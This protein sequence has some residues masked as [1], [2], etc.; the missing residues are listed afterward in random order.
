MVSPL[1]KTNVA[2]SCWM[3]ANEG[4]C[5][6]SAGR[7]DEFGTEDEL[8]MSGWSWVL[9]G[10]AILFLFLLLSVLLTFAVA[11][12]LGRISQEVSDLLEPEVRAST[13]PTREPVQEDGESIP[14][15]T[16]KAAD[17]ND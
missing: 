1:Q 5:G 7:A 11:V 10:V 9:L 4:V 14:S 2:R 6:P 12:I 3:S 17:G 13:P 8:N 16:R 15:E